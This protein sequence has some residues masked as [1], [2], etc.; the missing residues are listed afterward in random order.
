[1]IVV[2]LVCKTCL[3]PHAA[4]RD[5][6]YKKFRSLRNKAGVEEKIWFIEHASKTTKHEE[7]SRIN[8]INR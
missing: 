6:M 4:V 2:V 1:M 7:L 8:R 5:E 3:K